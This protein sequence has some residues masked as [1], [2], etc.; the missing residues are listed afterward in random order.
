MKILVTGAEGFVGSNLVRL[1]RRDHQVIGLDYLVDRSISNL[2]EEAQYINYDLSQV[3]ISDLPE[4]DLVIHLAAISIERISEIPTY[5]DINLTSM[6]KILEY[7]VKTK[8]DLVFSS[9]GSVYGSGINFT[10]TSPL[11]PL[12]EYSATK[13]LEENH[14]KFCSENYDLNVTILRYTNCYGDTTYIDN[15][16]YPGKKGVVRIFME[17]AVKD[18]PLPVIRNQSRD[19]TFIDDIVSATE[20]V[21]GLGGFNVFNVGTGVETKIETIVELIGH[22]LGKELSFVTAPNRKIDNLSR[23]SLNIDKIAPFWKPEYNLEEG[24]KLYAERF[25][26]KAK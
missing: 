25:K 20:S 18:E 13:I 1:L 15:K 5:K 14:A 9:T 3:N 8:A 12:S 7:V 23:R 21:I 26:E 2:P 16:F 10:E 24:I 19:F 17:K 4:V 6:F 11:N 22:T